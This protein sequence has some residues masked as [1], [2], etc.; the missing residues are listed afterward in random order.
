MSMPAA[1]TAATIIP[2]LCSR[3]TCAAGQWPCHSSGFGKHAGIDGCGESDCGRAGHSCRDRQGR[4][5][6][7]HASW[8]AHDA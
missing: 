2:G 4:T 1:H 7:S 3:N 8:T 5:F 6:G